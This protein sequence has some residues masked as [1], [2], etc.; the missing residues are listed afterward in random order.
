MPKPKRT[1]SRFPHLLPVPPLL[2]TL[3]APDPHPDPSRVVGIPMTQHQS[4]GR[5]SLDF[6]NVPFPT[7]PLPSRTCKSILQGIHFQENAGTARNLVIGT[8]SVRN[9]RP[10]SVTNVASPMSVWTI[11][12]SVSGPTNPLPT[13]YNL[14]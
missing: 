11:V 6:P 13:G 4:L 14:T 8:P 12:Q 9:R 1:H 3:T 7:S 10:I 5:T 2:A